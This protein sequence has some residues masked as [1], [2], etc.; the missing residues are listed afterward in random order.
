MVLVLLF[1]LLITLL[2]SNLLPAILALSLTM[3]STINPLAT[4]PDLI[5][6]SSINT[7]VPVASNKLNVKLPVAS[8]PI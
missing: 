7:P 6:F 1:I 5:P 2:I 3:A 8:F 4:A